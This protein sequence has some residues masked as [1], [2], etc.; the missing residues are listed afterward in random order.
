M[1]VSWKLLTGCPGNGSWVPPPESSYRNKPGVVNL[2]DSI[3]STFLFNIRIDPEERNE[4]SS[5]FPEMVS[6]LMKKLKKYNATAVPVR[7]P[8]PDPLSKPEL[9]GNVWTPRVH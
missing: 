2:F 7:Y 6:F 5:A 4:L 1:Y 9:Y 8:D 3:N